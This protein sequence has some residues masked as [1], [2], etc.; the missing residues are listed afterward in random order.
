[1]IQVRTIEQFVRLPPARKLI[2]MLVAMA[3]RDLASSLR[4]D[5]YPETRI[6]VWYFLA[7]VPYQLVPPPC[8]VWPFVVR[9]LRRHTTFAPP[10]RPPWWQR[11]R[12]PGD[13]PPTPVGGQLAIRLADTVARPGVLFF[14]GRTGEHVEVE[15]TDPHLRAGSRWF[16]GEWRRRRRDEWLIEFP[17]PGRPQ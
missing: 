16:G 8:S 15:T 10:D 2:T 13:F 9:E 6:D 12:R 4:F 5:C 3:G 17:D 1:M 7:G 14:R 11:F